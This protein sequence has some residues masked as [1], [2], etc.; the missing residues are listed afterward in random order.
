[1]LKNKTA[2]PL[3]FYKSSKYFGFAKKTST[4]NNEIKT[5]NDGQ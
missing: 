4:E 1:M 5:R 3:L 2:A